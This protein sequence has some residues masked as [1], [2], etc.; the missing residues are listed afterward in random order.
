MPK[1]TTRNP[2]LQKQSQ[3]KHAQVTK[4]QIDK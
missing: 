2:F 1:R 3:H 4:N